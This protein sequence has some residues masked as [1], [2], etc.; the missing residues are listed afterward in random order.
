MDK[1]LPHNWPWRFF[2]TPP[3]GSSPEH[4]HHQPWSCQVWGLSHGPLSSSRWNVFNGPRAWPKSG[5]LLLLL[6]DFRGGHP[7]SCHGP[8]KLFLL[9]WHCCF[10]L[11]SSYCSMFSIRWKE[12]LTLACQYFTTGKDVCVICGE[13]EN[14]SRDT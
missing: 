11:F 10:V 9:P 12:L 6:L 3:Q 1:I 5:F 14:L 4:L 8:G 7:Q 2:R 13:Q